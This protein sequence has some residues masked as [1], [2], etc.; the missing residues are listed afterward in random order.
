MSVLHISLRDDI[1]LVEE[2]DTSLT[3]RSDQFTLPF[4]QITPGYRA[5]F[6]QLATGGATEQQLGQIVLELDGHARAMHFYPMLR[7]LHGIGA[8]C[9]TL[10]VDERPMITLVPTAPV[11]RARETN[12]V[13]QQLYR[14][15]RFACMRR[16]TDHLIVESPLAVARVVLH[17]ERAP[18]LLGLLSHPHTVAALADRLPGFDE[19]S[20][21]LFLNLLL[22]AQLVVASDANGQSVEEEHPALGQWEFHDLLFHARSRLGRHNA[23]YGGTFPARGKFPPVPVAKQ[24]AV[25]EVIDLYRPDLAALEQRDPTLTTVLEQRRSIREQGAEPISAEQLGEF[26]YRVARIKQI[27]EPPDDLGASRRPYPSGGALYELEI[28]PVINRCGS[29][30]AGLY[31]Y[32]PRTHQLSKIAERTSYVDALLSAAAA[33]ALQAEQPQVCLT[34]T[35]RFQRVQWKYQSMAY[36]LILK[37]VGV[38]YQTMYLV[39]TAMG[40]APC[41]LGGGN[42]DLF[43]TAANL[44]YYAETSV[45]EFILGSVGDT[46]GQAI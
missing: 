9:Q 39:A 30:A 16:D 3:L 37:H 15:S 14:L 23:P 18:M 34:I 29:L 5:L 4:K 27:Y 17:D 19:T 13:A 21:M 8:L 41:A 31:H 28:Y 43:A 11:S 35:A 7:R 25:S 26:L 44:D 36:A 10:V 12:V 38:L 24:V 20:V 22:N 1:T 45:G 40:L 32:N 33:T 6:R 42:S 46:A 2:A